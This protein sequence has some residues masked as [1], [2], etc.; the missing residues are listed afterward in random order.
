MRSIEFIPMSVVVLNFRGNSL[1]REQ[2]VAKNK[3][4]FKKL[5]VC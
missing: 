1:M 4:F 3:L 2:F 5:F